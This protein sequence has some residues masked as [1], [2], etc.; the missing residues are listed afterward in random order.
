MMKGKAAIALFLTTFMAGC[1]GH[2]SR[3]PADPNAY[4]I[5]VPVTPAPGSSLQRLS[6]PPQVM[7]SL[8]RPDQR[9][10]RIFDG[11]GKPVPIAFLPSP[12]PRGVQHDIHL[13]AFPMLGTAGALDSTD[14]TLN[15]D[16][17][18]SSHTVR[19]VSVATND[20]KDV[21]AKVLGVLLDARQVSD[22]AVAIRLDAG[23]PPQQPIT[24]AI[25]AS[26]DLKTWQPL[27]EKVIYRSADR[28]DALG[29][30]AIPLDSVDLAGRYVRVTWHADTPLMGS[31]TIRGATLTLTSE[32]HDDDMQTIDA[33]LP[34]AQ[35]PHEVRFMVPFATPLQALRVIPSAEDAIL[36]VR[37]LRRD[38]PDQP[39][40][41]MGGG[42]ISSRPSGDKPIELSGQSFGEIEIEADRRTPGFTQPPRL[43]LVFKPIHLAVSF[44][45]PGPFRLAAGLKSAP[46][47]DLPVEDIVPGYRQGMEQRLPVAGIDARSLPAKLTLL[48]PGAGDR[49]WQQILL[50]SVLVA[51]TAVLGLMAWSLWRKSSARPPTD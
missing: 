26:D 41:P 44:G 28:A 46:D 14:V 8:Q 29:S 35:D 9:D 32:A 5:R 40:T 50:W 34:T 51:G 4:A 31:V 23:F 12:P 1:G 15:M 20:K 42:T 38:G 19:I 13:E 24:F 25:E 48:S 22:R 21:R 49:P 6:L 10:L 11:N 30:E 39:W 7:V 33:V 17:L 43:Q 37:I 36:P 47:N 18:H 45:G 27:A 16:A 3:D 2:R